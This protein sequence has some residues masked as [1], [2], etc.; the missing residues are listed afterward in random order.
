[1]C[2]AWVKGWSSGPPDCLLAWACLSHILLAAGSDKPHSSLKR[3]RSSCTCCIRGPFLSQ[4]HSGILSLFLK[5]LFSSLFPGRLRNQFCGFIPAHC[6]LLHQ[7]VR[8]L[9]FLWLWR[10]AWCVQCHQ[11]Q[12]SWFKPGRGIWEAG[13]LLDVRGRTDYLNKMFPKFMYQAHDGNNCLAPPG[14]SSC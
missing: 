13:H 7:Q 4:V 8:P 6:F 10:P 1:M 5:S 9:P 12:G 2:S 3:P 14:V 11:P